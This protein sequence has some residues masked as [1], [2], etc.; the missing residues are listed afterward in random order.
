[1]F[2]A[3]FY[4]FAFYFTLFFGTADLLAMEQEENSKIVKI[5]PSI[6]YIG[7]ENDTHERNKSLGRGT[8][9]LLA[10][11]AILLIFKFLSIQDLGRLASVSWEMKLFSE[12]DSLWRSIGAKQG[13]RLIVD[14]NYPQTVKQMV[15]KGFAQRWVDLFRECR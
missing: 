9:S 13:F 8:F 6:S 10:D 1:M 7:P 5:S 3:R 15:R 12:D 11:E 4:V 2:F 14:T